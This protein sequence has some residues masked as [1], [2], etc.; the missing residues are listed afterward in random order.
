MNYNREEEFMKG[1]EYKKKLLATK[2]GE[3]TG[4]EFCDLMEINIREQIGIRGN[5]LDEYLDWQKGEDH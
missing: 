2:I 5:A 4:R 3:L 1:E